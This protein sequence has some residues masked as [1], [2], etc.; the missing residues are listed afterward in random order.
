MPSR[1]LFSTL[2]Q[3]RDRIRDINKQIYEEPIPTSDIIYRR[4]FMDL[5]DSEDQTL[6]FL[7]IL[8]ETNFI[9]ILHIVEPDPILRI[10]G[11]YGYV[12]SELE[13]IESLL[14]EFNKKLEIL[15]EM[16]KQKKASADTIIREMI[17][18]IKQYNNSN[19][20]KVLNVCI[21]LD[22]F[23]RIIKEKPEEYQDTYRF[24]KLKQYLPKE[25]DEFQEKKIQREETTISVETPKRRAVDTEEYQELSRMNL[26]GNW[27]LA[28]QKFGVNFLI[29]V[30]LRKLEFDILKK[31]L[32]QKRIAR[33]EDLIFLRDSLRKMEERSLFDKELR[34]HLQEIRELKRIA[35][36]K[37]NQFQLLRKKY[38][39]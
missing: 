10:P 30:H 15:Y 8:S 2:I 16:E 4:Y 39:G 22:Q 18:Y 24:V 1:D 36:L 31:L 35:Q 26:S 23:I 20:G 19:L 29:R 5:T 13:I 37:I 3:I 27:G 12:V 21:M 34:N 17:P 33:E 11:I 25:E 14:R 28:V 6:Y 9:F 7:K 38:E 32:L